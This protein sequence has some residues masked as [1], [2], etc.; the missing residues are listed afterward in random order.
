MG[1]ITAQHCRSFLSK[2]KGHL[3]AS[4]C[5]VFVCVCGVGGADAVP[6]RED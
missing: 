3:S 1:T 4:V 6:Q 5:G 2:I